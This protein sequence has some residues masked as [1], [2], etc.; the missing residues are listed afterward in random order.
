MNILHFLCFLGKKSRG[1]VFRL[2]LYGL[3]VTMEATEFSCSVPL[4]TFWVDFPFPTSVFC[5]LLSI[6]E[7]QSFLSIV[8][9][10]H[11]QLVPTSKSSSL[12][13]RCFCIVQTSHT[14]VHPSP[15]HPAVSFPNVQREGWVLQC[16][17][18]SCPWMA[19]L[20]PMEEANP[21]VVNLSWI[22][23]FWPLFLICTSKAHLK[24]LHCRAEQEVASVSGSSG[25]LGASKT[26]SP[27]FRFHP[28]SL[29]SSCSPCISYLIWLWWETPIRK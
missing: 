26:W 10:F 15:L 18:N 20:E 29:S 6:S 27:H 14:A 9:N 21:A 8:N 23:P 24:C 25:Q 19:L 22:A 1:F 3:H 17:G 16:S 4:Q 28:V 13:A 5:M 12:N 7:E 2:I 11:N